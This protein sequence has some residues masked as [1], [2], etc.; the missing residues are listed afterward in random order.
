MFADTAFMKP[1]RHGIAAAPHQ[2]T[3]FWPK[4]TPNALNFWL[5]VDAATE[6]NGC[7]WVVPGSH[8][9]DLPH[10]SDPVM[11]WYLAE[12]QADFSQQIPIEL[13][14]GSAIFFDS[15]LIHRSY[16]NRSEHNRRSM[17]AIYVA[18]GVI[19]TEPWSNDHSFE[20]LK[21]SD[22]FHRLAVEL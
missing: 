17:T 8:D 5:A 16:P 14:A 3:A 22:Q 12:D 2:D 21:P 4:L 20:P 13:A 6:E 15:G 19:H 7:L 18:E 10:H 11:S 1:A 9:K